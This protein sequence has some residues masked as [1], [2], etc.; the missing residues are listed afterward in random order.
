MTNIIVLFV[1]TVF[2]F[3]AIIIGMK[4]KELEDDRGQLFYHGITIGLAIADLLI[5]IKCIF[6]FAVSKA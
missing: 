1:L 2:L 3:C 4:M 5:L 6:D